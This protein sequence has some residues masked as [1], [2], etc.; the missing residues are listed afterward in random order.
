MFRKRVLGSTWANVIEL[1]FPAVF[2]ENENQLTCNLNRSIFYLE[3]CFC[4]SLVKEKKLEKERS[5]D[6]YP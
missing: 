6:V 5:E 3:D 4:S 1:S 2:T